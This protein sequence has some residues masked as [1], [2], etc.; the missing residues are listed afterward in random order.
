MFL[1]DIDAPE[2]AYYDVE[3]RTDWASA[4]AQL[5]SLAVEVDA[6]PG[7]SSG[8]HVH[9]GANWMHANDRFRALFAFVRWEEVLRYLAAGRFPSVRDE[10]TTV[11]ASL[12]DNAS[13]T[14]LG[15]VYFADDRRFRRQSWQRICHSL[16]NDLGDAEALGAMET[17]YHTH[18]S[19]DRHSNLNVRTSH[20]TWEFRLWNSTRSAWRME[21]F[22]RLSVA[23][24]DP[25]VVTKLL[26]YSLTGEESMPEC[27]RKL[28]LALQTTGHGAT[29]ELV[30]RQADY[31]SRAMEVPSSFVSL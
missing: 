30:G 14:Y 18:Y 8:F 13:H 29:S 7:Y 1:H 28:R 21:L 27:L 15:S 11:G 26:E 19:S 20:G 2:V 16:L 22:T 6:E 12:R 23:L 9:V 17:M 31:L 24:V 10:N 5:E 25:A 3:P 4:M